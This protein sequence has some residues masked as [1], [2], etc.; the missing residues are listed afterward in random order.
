MSTPRVAAVMEAHIPSYLKMKLLKLRAGELDEEHSYLDLGYHVGRY[1]LEDFCEDH[2]LVSEANEAEVIAHPSRVLRRIFASDEHP[3]GD[4]VDLIP[5]AHR[6][7]F[8]LGILAGAVED[9]PGEG[10]LALAAA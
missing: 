9:E 4:F 8:L 7:D 6:R 10:W 5:H 3:R 1:H 2:S